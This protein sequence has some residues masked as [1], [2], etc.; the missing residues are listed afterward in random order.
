MCWWRRV[1]S[2]VGKSCNL[3]PFAKVMMSVA[4]G[5]LAILPHSVRWWVYCNKIKLKGSM[6]ALLESMINSKSLKSNFT[7]AFIRRTDR[8]DRKK[9]KMTSMLPPAWSM[10]LLIFN[11]ASWCKSICNPLTGIT[12]IRGPQTLLPPFKGGT[13]WTGADKPASTYLP[14]GF[15]MVG[16]K[17]SVHLIP[18]L[19]LSGP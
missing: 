9:R 10:V 14:L 2:E 19:W 5:P 11:Q 13:C 7:D 8:Q 6:H 16:W 18:P 12:R 4:N 15:H 17:Y 1:A 3:V